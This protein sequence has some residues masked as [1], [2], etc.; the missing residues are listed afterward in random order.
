MAFTAPQFNLTVNLWRW[1]TWN[2]TVPPGVAPDAVVM[3]QLRLYKTAFIMSSGAVA[4]I[5]V[6][7]CLPMRTDVR[8]SLGW[9][10]ALNQ[11][12][13]VEAP[14]GT[15]RYYVVLGVDDVARGFANEYRIASLRQQACP[16][17]LP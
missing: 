1:A 3:A 10:T 9:F 6:A 17:P 12:D 16:V 11:P 13:L 8:G 14:A 4:F 5:R 15:G 2:N 7:L